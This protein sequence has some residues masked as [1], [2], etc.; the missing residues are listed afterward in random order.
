MKISALPKDAD[1]L[2]TFAESI[3]TA[4]AERQEHLGVVTEVGAP[5]RA[6]IA[7]ATFASD[8]YVA[9]LAHAEKAPAARGSLAEAKRRRDRS[10]EQLRRRVTRSIRHLCRLTEEDLLPVR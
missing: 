6:A 1:A 8:A 9:A 5:L 10:V 4:L 7:A 3:A 2:V